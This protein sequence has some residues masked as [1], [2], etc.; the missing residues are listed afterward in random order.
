[1][2]K[3]ELYYYAADIDTFKEENR[4]K[5]RSTLQPQPA[6]KKDQQLAQLRKAWNQGAN[7]QPH[8][9]PIKGDIIKKNPIASPPPPL[10]TITKEQ[11]KKGVLNGLIPSAAYETACTSHT[12][13]VD[14]PFIQT[15]KP[16]TKIFVLADSHATTSSNIAKLH[17]NVRETASNVDMVTALEDS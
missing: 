4:A 1:M 13:M 6:W 15:N 12:G 7:K 8:A 9:H 2:S 5:G 16:S 3:Q 11:L 17:H 10:G 14:D